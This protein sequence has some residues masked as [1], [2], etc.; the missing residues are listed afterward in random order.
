MSRDTLGWRGREGLAPSG[1][2]LGKADVYPRDSVGDI[3]GVYLL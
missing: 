2:G 3:S 1:V